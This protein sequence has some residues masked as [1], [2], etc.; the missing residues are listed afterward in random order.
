MDSTVG[1]EAKYP[2]YFKQRRE[3]E[4]KYGFDPKTGTHVK[5]PEDI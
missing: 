4:T 3:F 1:Q 2:Q 5:V